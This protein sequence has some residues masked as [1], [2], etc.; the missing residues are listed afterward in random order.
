MV[1]NNLLSNKQLNHYAEDWESNAQEDA[2]YVILCDPKYKD[3][4]W[5]V[6]DF[7]HTGAEEIKR[8]FDFMSANK[9]HFNNDTFLDF[10][11]GAGRLSKALKTKFTS[12]YGID[13]SATMIDLAQQYVDGV[14]FIHNQQEN[15]SFIAN[16]TVDFVYSHIVLQHIPAQYQTKYISEFLRILK[17]DGLAVF[18]TPVKIVKSIGSQNLWYQTR[19]K[20]KK[21]FPVISAAKRKFS[22]SG[23][24]IEMHVLQSQII[25]QICQADNFTIELITAT[26]SIEYEHGKLKFYNRQEHEQKLLLSCKHRP[27]YLNYMYFVRKKM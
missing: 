12:G 3:N 19:Q 4:Q 7:Y 5:S 20:L 13:I 6:T 25:E 10:G 8:V 11:C 2:F 22:N 17:P 24:L 18:Q 27:E 1:F 9:I 26:N 23:I 14:H 15:L 21:I 16:N